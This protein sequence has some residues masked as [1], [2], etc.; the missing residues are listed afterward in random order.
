MPQLPLLLA[1]VLLASTV[2]PAWA[3]RRWVEAKGPNVT[4]ISDAGEG[5]ARD[6]AWQFEQIR[7]AVVVTFPWIRANLSRP[8]VAVAARDINTMRTL[9]PALFERP[10]GHLFSSSSAGGYDRAYVALRADI[11]LDDREGVSPYQSAYFQFGLQ[12]LGETA[13][14]LPLWLRRGLSEVISNTLVRD[15]EIQL[16][17][18]L[19]GHLDV[20]RS[21]GRM[22][23][24]DVVAMA[25]DDPR[26]NR[27]EFLGDFDANAWALVHFLLFADKGAYQAGFNAYVRGF[28]SGDEA[29]RLLASTIGD[30]SRLE[31]PFNVYINRNLFSYA[32]VAVSA[33]LSREG[34]VVRDVPPAE[35]L[36]VRAALHVAMQRPTEA[37]ALIGESRQLDA[38]AGA[39]EAEALLA[40]LEDR[41]DDVRTSLR[42]AVTQPRTSWYAPYRLATLTELDGATLPDV[43]RWLQRAT[44]LNPSADDA[45]AFLGSVLASLGR[46][47]EA[48]VAVGKAV[49]LVPASSPHRLTL[50]R[51]LRRLDRREEAMKAA[52]LA[53]ALAR[54][55]PERAAAQGL[56]AE[57][58]KAQL[59]GAE[60]ATRGA[61][62]PRAEA[63]DRSDGVAGSARLTSSEAP[64]AVATGPPVDL[65]E[66]TAAGSP[67]D[68]IG[69][70]LAS[71][72]S[73]ATTC[74]KALPSIAGA[75][76][77]G[78]SATS[79]AACRNAGYIL[80][81][82]IGV[83]ASAIGAVDY[84]RK[85]CA[86]KDDL[87]CVRLATMQAQGRGLARD[88]RAAV[89]VL[90][91]ACANGIQEGC[92]RLGVHL[93]STKVPAD[94]VRAR[95][96]LTASC[97]AEFAE[98]CAWL[99][100]RPP[101]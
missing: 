70:L 26:M 19:P 3:Q 94:A 60:S 55:Q 14:G 7:E 31:S 67:G 51:V 96:V 33:K 20:L 28:L 37:R 82:G 4:V 34:F 92:F 42:R 12:A 72:F 71:C 15:E 61:S 44:T 78:G 66:L 59:A 57:L 8:L 65:A 79:G 36:A 73:D 16:G 74:R 17:R 11:R 5:R 97:K 21:R 25:N 6:I 27:P 58:A 63:P 68:D 1:L 29:D 23:L 30:V 53:R 49:A 84:Y 85:G 9:V 77:D 45:W 46:G 91:D 48:I 18:M 2:A 83:P 76:N 100:K 89:R 90:E 41:D 75:C 43:E 39:D 32:K 35:A 22:A 93:S 56:L 24:R 95:E 50:A 13:A 54:T 87:S 98:S 99:E 101:P 52:G 86:R 64:A 10:D 47:D 40:D 81:V 38:A 69:S 62:G 88:V 80:D